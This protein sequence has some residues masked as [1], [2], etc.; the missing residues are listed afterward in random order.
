MRLGALHPSLLSFF[1]LSVLLAMVVAASPVAQA[2]TITVVNRD[3]AGEGFNDPAPR[4]PAGGNSGTT[5]GA[6]RFNA[7]QHAANIWGGL[8]DSPVTILVGAQFDPLA[9]GS[10]SAVLG[11]AAPKK[12]ARDF[13]G[14]P[15]ASTWYPIALANALSGVDLSPGPPTDPSA[16]DIVAFF[17]S[18]IGTTC[19]FPNVWY[20]GLDGNPPANQIDFVTVVL[21]ELGHGLGFMTV[22]NLATGAKLAGFND[23]FMRH[24]EHHGAS[25]SSYPNMTDAGRVAASMA[26]G[27]LHWVGLAVRAFSGVL[28]TGRVGDH[29][30]MFAPNPQRP[31]SSVSHWDTV[32]G[33]N[34]LMEP[35]YTGPLHNPDLELP[36]FFDIGWTL[37][38]GDPN[39]SVV[40]A[41]KDFGTVFVGASTDRTFT[42]RNNGTATLQVSGTSIDGPF[43]ILDGVN[44]FNLEPG[45]TQVTVR[46]TPT[47]PAGIKNG[48]LR[49]TS[50]DPDTP[51]KDVAL[52]GTA[53]LPTVTIV[54]L[55]P[56]ASETSPNTGAFKVLRTGPTTAP[57]TVNYAVSGTADNGSD[58]AA[59]PGTVT[60]GAGLA[61]API[62][63]TPVDDT[64]NGEG[65]E[66]VV[67]TLTP[68][69]AAYIVGTPGTAT[70]TIV[71]NDQTLQFSAAEYQVLEGA[72]NAV[73]RVTRVGPATTQ[74]TVICHTIPGGTAVPNQD[75]RD[76]VRKLTFAVGVRVQSCLVPVL[77]D[78][79]PDGLRTVHLQLDT[80][81]GPGAHLGSIT[82]AVLTIVDNQAG[83]VQFAAATATVGE[84][85]QAGLKV[86]RTG[87]NLVGGVTVD[88]SVI[89]GTATNG[90]DPDP[91]YNLAGGTLTFD[92]GVATMQILLPTE[93]DFLFEGDET[94]IVR[95]SN[96]TGG[97]ALGPRADMTVTIKDDEQVLQFTA[98][99]Y[100]VMEGAATAVIGV[101]RLGPATTRVT[102]LCSTVPGGTAVPDQDYR[103]VVRTIVFAVGVRTQ[104][105]LVPI[106][107]DTLVDGARTVNLALSMP[108]GTAQLGSPSTAELTINDND[109][110][111]TFRFG[112]PTFA[113]TEG[114][115]GVL[116]VVRSGINLGRDVTVDYAVT[117]GSAT[118]GGT[119]YTLDNGTL[120]FG[121]GQTG[122]TI[123]VPTTVDT[124]F[125]GS[126][127]VG[128]MLLNASAGGTIAPSAAET[129][130]TIREG[131]RA[132]V[133]FINGLCINP[134][135][136]SF[137]AR[138]RAEEGNTWFSTSGVFS[139]Y[140]NV[141]RASVSN[142]VLTA[143][144]FPE[145]APVHF[146]GSF[147][148]TPNRRYRLVLTIS[149]G[150]LT[151]LQIDEGAIP[152]TSGLLEFDQ[153]PV[154]SIPADLTPHLRFGPLREAPAPALISGPR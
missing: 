51:D 58:Y 118:G 23:A 90:P 113:V 34:Q 101:R 18:S 50:D 116:K 143:I 131:T 62:V 110:A 135:C 70:V 138:L 64:V 10:T 85:L 2:A 75:Y 126:E 82:S 109:R 66:T 127:T 8:L 133:R 88:Y 152:G 78:T 35:F 72:I 129:T 16:D 69:A 95:L 20:Y 79:Q 77:N 22:V 154:R 13:A 11:A 27:S 31:G 68:D 46:F 83:I 106:L 146:S 98:A 17:N 124:L 104:S 105:C 142:F 24:L 149:G 103:D 63:V 132:Q 39:I 115:T 123:R 80:P 102:V 37:A 151:L 28:S 9:C 74:V 97:A 107:N 108:G 56:T 120:T 111:G 84:G 44:A 99:T 119:D 87:V 86:I 150:G 49:F 3:G 59:L 147:A 76:V 148:L 91:D 67:V 40:P 26:T 30:R 48:T 137:T 65:N 43:S 57:L 136:Q 36:L 121:A 81:G 33:P 54:A 141:K 112:A 5:L 89:G 60:I 139:A 145:I 41:S 4:A 96:A 122:A 153:S 15:V 134:G 47:A 12:A 73:I 92:A 45:E 117:G 53:A 93:Q 100:Q 32:L 7:F 25:P 140:Q 125:E 19:P 14:A 144:E 71:E 29:V 38:D 42:V 130:L 52:T 21:H 55:D 1:V 61:S 6:Q 94:V 114:G 128:V